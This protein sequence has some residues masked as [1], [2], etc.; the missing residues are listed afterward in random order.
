MLLLLEVV[1]PSPGALMRRDHL[2]LKPESFNSSCYYGASISSFSIF[3]W[4][5]A[6]TVY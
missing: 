2:G 5:R 4:A 3:Y 1:E 6:G